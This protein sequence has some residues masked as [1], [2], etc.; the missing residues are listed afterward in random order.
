MDKEV[1]EGTLVNMNPWMNEQLGEAHRADLRR[2]AEQHAFRSGPRQARR[3]VG[4]MLV[5]AGSRV[6]GLNVHIPAAGGAERF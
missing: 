1:K 6:G 4:W 3:R 5:R 2:V